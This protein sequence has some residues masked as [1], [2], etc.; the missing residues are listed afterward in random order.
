[1]RRLLLPLLCAL[2]AWAV[3]ISAVRIEGL[4]R[5]RE[6]VVQRELRL[7][8]G[9]KTDSASLAEDA[10]RLERLGIFAEIRPR[11][12]S[13]G[14]L[15]WE[16][17]ELPWV[18]P[19]PN[20]R[21][22]DADGLSLGFGVKSPNFLGEAINLEALSLFGGVTEW[23]VAATGSWIAGFPVGWD[24]FTNRSEREAPFYG[25]HETSLRNQF[26]LRWPS[27]QLLRLEAGAGISWVREGNA[28]A[29]VSSDRRDWIP[30]VTIGLQWDGR[31]R[32]GLTR[33]GL[34]QELLAERIGG[35]LG[36]DLD[37]W[38]LTSDTRAWMPLS[39]RF[40]IHAANLCEWQ[41]GIV[42]AWRGFTVGG[43]NSA[44]FLPAAELRGRSEDLAALELRW[45]LVEP[46]AVAL[47]GQSLYWG[48]QALAGA[49]AVAAWDATWPQ[50]FRAGPVAGFDVLV[51]YVGRIRFCGGWSSS[52]GGA[53]SAAVGLDEKTVAQRW[54]GR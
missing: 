37:G 24:V 49:E 53:I 43:A 26:L 29:T 19:V 14:T 51:P 27:D 39:K 48:L 52:T 12:D 33:K 10:D 32:T 22:S 20:G 23:Q 40:G 6:R 38:Q 44:R 5:T 50:D 2:P 3:T 4:S 1:M 36:G 16:V 42:D 17:K 35:T 46:H 41:T 21:L 28:A 13:L 45:T 54:K 11:L 47:M 34:Y 18:L 31:D 9:D 15:T 8:V 30:S 25:G 7:A